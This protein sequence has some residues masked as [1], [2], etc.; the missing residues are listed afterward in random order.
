MGFSHRSELERKSAATTCKLL[1]HLC[2]AKSIVALRALAKGYAQP[3]D[4]Q[5]ANSYVSR[6]NI[7]P[8]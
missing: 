2:F 3:I 5:A 8:F 6:P 7:L 1:R 4:E